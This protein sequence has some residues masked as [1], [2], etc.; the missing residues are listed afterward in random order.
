MNRGKAY[1]FEQ[2]YLAGAK[3]IAVSPFIDTS[4]GKLCFCVPGD[5]PPWSGMWHLTGNVTL[6]GDDYFEF[7]CDDEVM[8]QRGGTYRFHALD[9]DTFRQETSRWVSQGKEI[10]DN[11]R[12][13]DDLHAW[14]LE[15][16]PNTCCPGSGGGSFL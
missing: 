6:D 13:T 10:A 3:N 2:P 4:D 1:W 12:S 11:C 5:D 15:H 14:Y 7:K 16:W 9:M 8:C